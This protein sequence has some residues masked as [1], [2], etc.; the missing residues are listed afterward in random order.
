MD[1]DR[2]R[3]WWWPVLKWALFA[4]VMACVALKMALGTSASTGS[5]RRLS[6]LVAT[7]VAKG[8]RLLKEHLPYLCDCQTKQR[9][10]RKPLAVA[11]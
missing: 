5:G 9:E 11:C 8:I 4:V 10:R 1:N 3:R 6:E 7:Q 2:G